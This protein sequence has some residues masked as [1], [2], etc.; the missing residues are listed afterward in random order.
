MIK[1]TALMTSALLASFW[2]ALP[3]HTGEAEQLLV[4]DPWLRVGPPSQRNTAGY[5]VLHNQADRKTALV[6][7]SS[8]IAR[9]GEL[10]TMDI[11]DDGMMSMQ[12]ILALDIDADDQVTLAPGGDH[13]MFI[14]LEE[15]LTE[16]EQYPVTLEFADGTRMTV[17]FEARLP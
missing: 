13:L 5:M 8:P 14:G 9:T 15:T 1:K 11:D 7:V 17:D 2:L 4:E 6:G 10:H 3:G 12:R 16:G